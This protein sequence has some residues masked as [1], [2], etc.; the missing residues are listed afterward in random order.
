[1]GVQI[2]ARCIRVLTTVDFLDA[3]FIAA[4]QLS[5]GTMLNGSFWPR[6]EVSQEEK[7]AAVMPC[8][9]QA[10]SVDEI[11]ALLPAPNDGEDSARV[12]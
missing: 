3:G 2:G 6:A 9:A 5:R 7:C 4:I 8:I 12:S 1:M 10:T 11:E